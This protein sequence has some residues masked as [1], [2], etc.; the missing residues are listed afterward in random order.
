LSIFFE[1]KELGDEEEA[2]V[3]GSGDRG[4]I[5]KAE[6]FEVEGETEEGEEASEED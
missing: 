2:E 4:G 5:E 3:E 1:E 6:A